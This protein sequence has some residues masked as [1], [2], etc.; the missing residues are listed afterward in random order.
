MWV[1]FQ[2]TDVSLTAAS[3]EAFQDPDGATI[4]GEKAQMLALAMQTLN[5]TQLP[6]E[7]NVLNCRQ[8]GW[9]LL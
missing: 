2:K 3:Y 4:Y 6:T 5:S 8:S 7:C 9:N 1:G